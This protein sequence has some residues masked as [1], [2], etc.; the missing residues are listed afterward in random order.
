MLH[1]FLAS[2]CLLAGAQTAPLPPTSQGSPP[3]PGQDAEEIHW[4]TDLDLALKEAHRRKQPLLA[5][6]R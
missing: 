6:F 1:P 5:V 3:G 4:H 2:I